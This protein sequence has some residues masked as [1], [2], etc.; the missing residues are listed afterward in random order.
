MKIINAYICAIIKI[1][2]LINSN[3]ED[4]IFKH[5]LYLMSDDLK[6]SIYEFT[7]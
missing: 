7:R 5:L 1:S 3:R 4:L 6:P 2:S